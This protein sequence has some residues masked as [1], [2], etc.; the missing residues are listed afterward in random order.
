MLVI[1]EM[2]MMWHPLVVAVT[3]PQYKGLSERERERERENI[4]SWILAK[5]S[6]E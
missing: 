1:H 5:V 4:L 2:P 6:S 3:V